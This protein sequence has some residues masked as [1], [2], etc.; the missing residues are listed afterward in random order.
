[1]KNELNAI[2]L[3][4]D[5]VTSVDVRFKN[6]P[7][8][9]YTY[10]TTLD[11][12]EGDTAIVDSPYG[13]YRPVDVIAVRPGLPTNILTAGYEYKF[14]VDVVNTTR[15]LDS[16]AAIENLREELARQQAEEKERARQE[17]LAKAKADLGLDKNAA[18]S[19]AVKTLRAT[20]DGKTPTL[21]EEEQEV[22][23]QRKAEA[24]L[25]RSAGLVIGV[26][27]I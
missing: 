12:E 9:S 27:K 20:L 24:G 7:D 25:K 8:K 23:E 17:A 4:L 6:T 10:L 21:T 5:T 13:G 1:M 11:V 19:G 22:L 15:Y 16:Q 14:L 26:L 2:A 18:L 3:T